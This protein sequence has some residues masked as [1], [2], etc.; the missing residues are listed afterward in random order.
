MLFVQGFL[1]KE[2]GDQIANL[3]EKDL[4]LLRAF[5]YAELHNSEDVS[6]ALQRVKDALQEKVQEVI[7]RLKRQY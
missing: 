3:D 1:Q 2:F 4:A 6:D 7:D 5:L